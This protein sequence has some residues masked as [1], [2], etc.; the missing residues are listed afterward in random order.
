MLRKFERS[1]FIIYNSLVPLNKHSFWKIY[2]KQKLW[3]D[4]SKVQHISPPS[5]LTVCSMRP[6]ISESYCFPI[7]IGLT[8]GPAF[9]LMHT[10]GGSVFSHS[11]IKHSIPSSLLYLIVQKQELEAGTPLNAMEMFQISLGT[12]ECI[13]EGLREFSSTPDYFSDCLPLNGCFC[14]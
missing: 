12:K 10:L 5:E 14:P 9:Y 13:D 11:Y 2:Y 4:K 3:W 6:W 7:W 1:L 8:S